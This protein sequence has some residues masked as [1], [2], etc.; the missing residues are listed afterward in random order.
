LCRFNLA[1]CLVQS[2][3]NISG[4]ICRS[5]LFSP[6]LLAQE[7][8]A[9]LVTI[10]LIHRKSLTAP[11]FCATLIAQPIAD[12]MFFPPFARE[13][14]EY[15]EPSGKLCNLIDGSSPWK[16]ELPT[17]WTALFLRIWFDLCNFFWGNV[18]KG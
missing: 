2:G 9:A 4:D 6:G 11:L 14:G 16:K 8:D 1:V 12:P 17:E 3:I 5:R 13:K 15:S 7:P 10:E 18:S